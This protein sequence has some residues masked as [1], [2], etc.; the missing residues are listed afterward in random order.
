VNSSIGI[1]WTGDRSIEQQIEE[2]LLKAA[3]KS[4][5]IAGDNKSQR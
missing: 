1:R 5:F 3:Q 2:T 4:V